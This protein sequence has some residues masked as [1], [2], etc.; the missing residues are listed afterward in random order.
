MKV[1]AVPDDFWVERL[2]PG[3][4]VW[5]SKQNQF[6]KVFLPWYPPEPGCRLGQLAIDIFNDNKFIATQIWS[7]SQSGCGFDKKQLI[8]PIEGHVADFPDPVDNS[9]VME[10]RRTIATLGRRVEL[11]EM[12]LK[13]RDVNFLF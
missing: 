1:M 11:L 6:A 9:T 3:N 5:L 2:R 7:V 12:G 4:W 13:V 10:L 8:D